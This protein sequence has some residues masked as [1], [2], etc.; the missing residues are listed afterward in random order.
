METLNYST[1]NGTKL[2]YSEVGKETY[3]QIK[4]L[5]NVPDIGSEPKEIDTTSLD[6]TEYETAKYGLKKAVKLALEFNLEDPTAEANIK[7]AHDLAKSKKIYDFKIELPNGIT[8]KFQSKVIISFKGGKSD[9]LQKF[10]MFLT[11]TEEVK[12]EITV[13]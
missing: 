13:A 10:E 12:T 2:S 8:H 5:L 1:Y 9:E 3:K 7:V 6:N 11:P 4:G